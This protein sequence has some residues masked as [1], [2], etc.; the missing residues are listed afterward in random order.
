M[1]WNGTTSDER[2]NY[3]FTLHSD[4]LR[5]GMQFMADAIRTPL[6]LQEELER[7]RHVVIGEYD[8]AE[9]D[10]GFH[11][12]VEVG[13][14]LWGANWVRKNVIGTRSVILSATREQMFTIQRRFYVPNNSALI[15]AGAVRAAEVEGLAAEFFGSWPQ[16]PDPFATDPPP[17]HAPLSA[18]ALRVV[19]RPVNAV[20][21]TFAWHG[22]SVDQDP[23][24]TY[25]A[26][27]LSFV[28]G[29]RNSRFYRR[30]VDSGLASRASLHYQTLRY[31][32][33]LQ[34][35]LV[36]GAEHFQGA[37]DTLRD[38]IA[39]LVDDDAFS[40]DDLEAAKTQLEI[41]Q[42]YDA[43]RPSQLVHTLGY[44]WAVAGLEYYERY[45]E[46]LRR[47]DRDALRAFVRRYIE[48]RPCVTG[49]LV[50][51]Q[52]RVH[53]GKLEAWS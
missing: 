4:R 39:H 14:A 3:Y 52:D 1:E 11:L 35:W 12:H 27:V 42:V 23:D 10:P 50:S 33:P 25:A 22:P 48:G 30:L 16:A 46:R 6:F 18:P 19:E 44:W 32:G 29:Q 45:V 38:E 8:R 31:T 20:S 26:D 40:D 2:V 17:R 5:D 34:L 37:Y 49:A 43:E 47:I 24:G 36:C 28:L 53:L 41:E 9:A 21:L 7:E 15:V 51:P 13:Q